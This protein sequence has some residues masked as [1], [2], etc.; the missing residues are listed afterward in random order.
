MVESMDTLSG[1]WNNTGEIQ[2][3]QAPTHMIF[4]I[5]GYFVDGISSEDCNIAVMPYQ[6][7][8]EHPGVSA[9]ADKMFMFRFNNFLPNQH[10]YTLPQPIRTK[11]ISFVPDP[12][13]IVGTVDLILYYTLDKAS[14]Q[15]L[16][17]E[18]ISKKR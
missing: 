16:I 1:F 4:E 13:P 8:E 17:W 6:V 7:E 12:N 5:H 9:S 11:F 15:E 3:Y 10:S 14:V 2:R 18:F